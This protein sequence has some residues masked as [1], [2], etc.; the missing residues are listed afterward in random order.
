MTTLPLV[1]RLK[2]CA[3]YW[4][5]LVESHANGSSAEPGQATPVRHVKAR[6]ND[7]SSAHR[8][9]VVDLLAAG[10]PSA[11]ARFVVSVCVY[12]IKRVALRS[13]THVFV[14]LQERTTPLVTH[15]NSTSAVTGIGI[16]VRIETSRLRVGPTLVFGHLD[17]AFTGLELIAAW[18]VHLARAAHAL[19]VFV[20]RVHHI[21]GFNRSAITPAHPS[22]PFSTRRLAKHDQLAV[23]HS[24]SILARAASSHVANFTAYSRVLACL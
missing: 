17:R 21:D 16:F 5:T 4:P 13:R 6:R 7:L 23:S 11:V 1:Q 14:E 22:K 18:R 24:G 8:P 3:F 9:S 19:G 10:G 12:A 20:V 2:H 15:R